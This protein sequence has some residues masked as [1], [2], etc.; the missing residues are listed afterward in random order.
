MSW[1]I[2]G[3]DGATVKVEINE[4]EYNGEFMG[5]SYVSFTVKSPYPVNFE[6]GDK[7]EYRGEEYT[8][9]YIP[10]AVKKAKGESSAEAF[11]YDNV[12]M[13]SASDELARCDFLD[14]VIEDN[15]VHFTSLPTFSFYAATVQDL[16]DRIQANLDRLYTGT[17]KWTVSV[18]PSFNGK[19]D[20]TVDVN[21]IK[22]WDAL[23]LANSLFDANFIIRGRT[24]T[25]GTDGIAIPGM[26]SY[27][28]WN[29]LY[30]IGQDADSDQAIITRLRAYGSTK[31]LPL[32]YYN[33]L[34]STIYVPNSMTVAERASDRL[35]N[36]T[37]Y[38][39]SIDYSEEVFGPLGSEMK[40]HFRG[41]S[42][43][44]T[45]Y[46]Q[47]VEEKEAQ[48]DDDGNWVVQAFSGGISLVCNGVIAAADQI[49]SIESGV[50][51][52]ALPEGLKATNKMPESMYVN[53]LMLPSFPY[54][55]ADPYL[56]SD[57]VDEIGVREASVFFDGT[58][59]GLDE[60][61]P[62]IEGITSDELR[63][64]GYQISL[65]LGDNGHLDEILDAEQATDDGYWSDLDDGDEIPNFDIEIKDIG[66]DINDYLL[67]GSEAK[68]S[69]KSGMLGGRE[70]AISSVNRNSV[71]PGYILNCQR[72]KDSDLD[73]YFP[74]KDYNMKPGDKF[75][76]LDISMPKVYIDAASQRLE[77]A[78]KEYLSKNDTAR[79]TY[80]PKIDEIFMARQ[81]DASQAAGSTEE[82][83]HDTLKEGDILSFE[84]TE[85]GIN[86]SIIIDKLV[87]KE[88]GIIPSYDVVLREEKGTGTIQRM[89]AQINSI[90]SGRYSPIS[91]SDIAAIRNAIKVETKG[92]GNVVTSVYKSPEG[93]AALR[94]ITV[95]TTEEA[96]TKMGAVATAAKLYTDNK[97]SKVVTM[98]QPSDGLEKIIVSGGEDRTS[99]STGLDLNRLV[100]FGT[101]EDAPE[102]GVIPVFT[103][104]TDPDTN[105]G[106]VTSSGVKVGDL[107][108]ET[109][110]P[111]I[112][113]DSK[114]GLV[115]S[116]GDVTVGSDGTV[117]VNLATNA[118]NL[119]RLEETDI[120]AEVFSAP[121]VYLSA[122]SGLPTGAS[123]TLSLDGYSLVVVSGGSGS[124]DVLCQTVFGSVGGELSVYTRY[125]DPL[126]STS[127]FSNVRP[128]I[129][130]AAK[131]GL[132]KSGGDITVGETG[133]MSVSH[134][135]ASHVESEAGGWTLDELANELLGVLSGN[136]SEHLDLAISD[137]RQSF[138]DTQM[139][140]TDLSM[141][142]AYVKDFLTQAD[143]SDDTINRWKEIE[144][145]LDGI[146]DTDTLTGLLEDSVNESKQY[147]DNKTANMVTMASN[148]GATGRVL[149]S[150]AANK[151][152]KDSGVLL[153]DLAKKSELPGN[154]T[155]SSAGLMSAD[156][157][158]KLDGI[159]A[160]A[161][162]Y[163]LPVATDS[164]L[165][166]VKSGGDI[167]VD[168][169]GN[170]TVNKA[171][172]AETA[173]NVTNVPVATSSKVGGVKSGGDIT[174][175]AEG[176]V[177][178]N[179]TTTVTNVPVATS[180]KVGGVKSGTDIVVSG[181]GSVK[182][183]PLTVTRIHSMGISTAYKLFSINGIGDKFNNVF[184][185]VSPVL[186]GSKGY[187]TYMIYA[188][189]QGNTVKDC[190]PVCLFATETSMYNRIK[191]VRTGDQS[192]DV[193]Y[194]SNSGNDYCNFILH[195]STSSAITV[196]ATGVSAIPEDIYKESA[197]VPVYFG[198][199]YGSL[200]GNA[201]T[202]TK[203]TQ[204]GNGNNIADTY[205]PK[206]GGTMSGALTVESNVFLKSNSTTRYLQIETVNNSGTP[207]ISRVYVDVNAGRGAFL[208]FINNGVAY[209]LGVHTDGAPRYIKG[210][211]VYMLYHAGN[212]VNATTS[213]AGLMSAT[214]KAKLDGID[215][216]ANNYTLPAASSSAL[217]GIK[218]GYT[219]SGKNYPVELDGNGQAYVN[220]P[221]ENS[222]YGNATTTAAGL[223]SADDKVAL[224]KLN[225]NNVESSSGVWA[226]PAVLAGTTNNSNQVTSIGVESGGTTYSYFST[227][228]NSVRQ[229]IRM[230]AYGQNCFVQIEAEKYTSYSKNM[231][232]GDVTIRCGTGGTIML[233]AS[234]SVDTGTV[235][236]RGNMVFHTPSDDNTVTVG[237]GDNNT[238][239]IPNLN[240][241]GSIE[242][243]HAYKTSDIRLK[244]N[245]TLVS[246]EKC[247]AADKLQIREFDYKNTGKHS[248]GLIAQEVEEVLPDM[249]HTD[250][251]GYK[252][253]DYTEYLLMKVSALEARIA[254]LERRL[255]N[256]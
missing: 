151:T 245:I 48:Y 222:T 65:P 130:D 93:V 210:G 103:G 80:T 142:I 81:H 35:E 110:L 183:N 98:E 37:Y 198:D 25:I 140:W 27:G 208:Q 125:S 181:D 5:E 211:T 86:K 228:A 15:R 43:T 152:A 254:E 132:V 89:Q 10:G 82:S 54:E 184:S 146:T 105:G 229:P 127:Y 225:E 134:V 120:D 214:D 207:F 68:I 83:L 144:D 88:G 55:T 171:T 126:G 104:L 51:F 137:L 162:K 19:S 199:I 128:G 49:Y 62:T 212:L 8:L 202:A 79:L 69:M 237:V 71:S 172:N 90:I 166:G 205:L 189:W 75:V 77:N 34:P 209:E 21:N 91:N 163:V 59:E 252:S 4:L 216:N 67:A 3:K 122:I 239:N 1:K 160:R 247:K 64:A 29:G 147:T 206:T 173:T 240:V 31:N 33:D 100:V 226:F 165:G 9:E 218:I 61:Y 185:I 39:L 135:E 174:V 217:G 235:Y 161:N 251:K 159:A 232:N 97:V 188:P 12:K 60:I 243:A 203:A 99:K 249:V 150:A 192:F 241:P 17:K 72:A 158:T 42:W 227:G 95:Y 84:D 238:L 233:D 178:V 107:A 191:L 92:G 118:K 119:V 194:Q 56:D 196:I 20:V 53:R 213:K 38:H 74:N 115:K 52:D 85:L 108:K 167:S 148:A 40:F 117:T 14:F 220:V 24:V 201:D 133:E 13:S 57:H 204:D 244:K 153:S 230:R 253:I 138:Y 36:K 136:D 2:Y 242:T 66:F 141:F 193:Y 45:G 109:D 200:K 30:E 190:Y 16:A 6:I 116:G 143:V 58:T 157:K 186:G 219:E 182:V 156:D 73:M 221:W 197:Y 112:A 101:A 234:D 102:E 246:G 180:S 255:Y 113:T 70:F 87:I 256:G 18:S 177:T 176:N 44:V 139:G 32:R 76:L 231:S 41:Q 123:E 96:D 164:A 169:S 179:S 114:A 154:A 129:A 47:Q 131:A 28:K 94:D 23:A 149:V 250:G 145:F 215:D 223:M 175:D 195:C 50:D 224:D 26:F 7:L 111:G 22:V 248:V 236:V 106:S 46:W 63:E 121:G 170:V 124:M 155:G 187:A 168:N 78:A 11:V